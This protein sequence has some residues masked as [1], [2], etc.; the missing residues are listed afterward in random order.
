[1]VY[2]GLIPNERGYER[3]KAGG[4]CEVVLVGA[5]TEGYCRVNLKR[6]HSLPKVTVIGFD[7]EGTVQVVPAQGAYDHGSVDWK[8]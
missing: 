1:M 2:G 5:T 6:Q 3:A 7:K 4:I 8:S